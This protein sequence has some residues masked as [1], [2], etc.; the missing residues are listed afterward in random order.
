MTNEAPQ[1]PSTQVFVF[2]FSYKSISVV[3]KS[4]INIPC[5][6][7]LVLWKLQ[8][9]VAS[10]RTLLSALLVSSQKKK[11]ILAVLIQSTRM[12]YEYLSNM[13]WLFQL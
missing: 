2:I 4:I 5:S 7:N 1:A 6:G 8:I 3:R 11:K 10:D 9:S 13:Q 12:L